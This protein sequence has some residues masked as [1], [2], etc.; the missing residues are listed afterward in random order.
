MTVGLPVPNTDQVIGLNQFFLYYKTP[1]ISIHENKSFQLPRSFI[2][3]VYF[4]WRLK[5][6]GGKH[7]ASVKFVL[8]NV[9]TDY[10]RPW[11][12]WFVQYL[13][14]SPICKCQLHLT[15]ILNNTSTIL[16]H[17]SYLLCFTLLDSACWGCRDGLGLKR[18]YCIGPEL[19]S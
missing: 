2:V 19:R 7:W 14:H 3:H 10:S 4:Y 18:G 15:F 12:L 5:T 8:S 1:I 6:R 13:Y 9:L 11:L 16:L 17:T